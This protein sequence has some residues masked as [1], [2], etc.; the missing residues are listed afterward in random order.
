[1][2]RERIEVVD[3]RVRREAVQRGGR[4]AEADKDD[5]KPAAFAVL[6]S[7]S[8]SP[9][10]TAAGGRRRPARSSRSDARVGL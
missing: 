2:G 3:H 7:T 6:T 4:V 9:I 1:M 8:L 5:G 10:I